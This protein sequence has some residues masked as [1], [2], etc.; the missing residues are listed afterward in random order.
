MR[1]TPAKR[2]AIVALA[3]S[4]NVT[5]AAAL[6]QISRSTL[7]RWLADDEFLMA[8]R[9]YSDFQTEQAARRLTAL[10]GRAV[11]TLE[12]LLDHK[13]PHVRRLAAGNIIAHAVRLS[14]LA[15]LEFRVTILE[16]R[17]GVK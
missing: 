8:L 15:S 9:E 17:S 3:Q 11:D 13:S 6:A 5:E 10:L 12:E 7:H 2:R 1:I 4:P 16:R 14:E